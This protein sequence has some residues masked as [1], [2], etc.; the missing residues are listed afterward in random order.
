ML[1]QLYSKTFVIKKCI[2]SAIPAFLSI[3]LFFVSPAD[4]T[5][6]PLTTTRLTDLT[7][8]ETPIID[9]NATSRYGMESTSVSRA[10][11]DD[12]NAQD[13]TSA[14]RRVP[15][16][17]ISRF[18]QVGS[19]GGAQ[20]GGVFV[21]GGGASRPGGELQMLY[22]G[23]PRANPLFNHPLLDFI[24]TDPAGA[25]R[26]YKGV[27]P[28]VYGN[29]NA[30][31]DVETKRMTR[32]GFAT[33]LA[34][35]YGSNN[36][37]IQSVEHGGKTGRLDYYLGESYKHSDGHRDHSNGELQ[38]YYSRLGFQTS[39]HWH[40][41]WFGNATDNYAL[42][43]GDRRSPTHDNDG[44]YETRD[45][46][47]T[48]TFSN[49]YSEA[50]G[51]IKPYYV[52]GAA[53][54]YG[55]TS[56][57]GGKIDTA[58]DWELYGVRAKETI[59]PWRGGE[60]IV[61]ID[62]DL[63]E[64][65]YQSGASTFSD[66]KLTLT[67]PYLA[68]SHDIDIA[69]WT[70]TPSV[71]AR[72]YFHNEFDAETAPQAGLVI[73]RGDSAL[74]IGYARG[75]VYPGL[76]VAVFSEVISPPIAAANPQGWRNLSAEVMDHYEAGVSRRFNKLVKA[77][78]TVFHDDGRDRYQ[79]YVN[80]A[81]GRPGGFANIGEYDKDGFESALTI[82]PM[83][84][85]S[86]FVGLAYLHT[87]PDTMPFA[88]EWTFSAGGNWRF[89]EHFQLSI[90]ALWR[91]DMYTDSYSRAVAAPASQPESV[92]DAFIMNAK[93]AYLFAAPTLHVEKGEA[94]LAFE[95]LTDTSYEYA[96]GYDMAG[97]TVMAGFSFSF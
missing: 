60:I 97:F 10:Q 53:R 27:Q 80:P 67:S 82:T 16:V 96:P 13:I 90:D 12:M 22:D 26:V 93:I 33:K 88:P 94:F 2:S 24:S 23:V 11:M 31:V 38:S 92:D 52:K 39:D 84:D 89:L 42:D 29:G 3:G 6:T 47:N 91:D 79:M 69:G 56:S 86:L 64:G 19:F 35:Q 40:L 63:V 17:T 51:F 20:G 68:V 34:A 70:L 5:E 21:R 71:G 30:A 28:E 66:E 32:D 8:I 87:D 83:D 25:V 76:N 9:S 65:D 14:L 61:G 36:T 15:G 62:L 37:F 43:P 74:H 85:V 77:N 81:T 50:D 48:L 41:A 4:A 59:R 7:V 58:M 49:S 57:S 44:R 78:F 72:Q 55:E 18:D 75:V 73:S 54:W 1:K 95:N 45:V 46:F